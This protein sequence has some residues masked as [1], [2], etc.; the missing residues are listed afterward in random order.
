V[1][2]SGC[3]HET[4]VLLL[5]TLQRRYQPSHCWASNQSPMRRAQWAALCRLAALLHMTSVL[6][7]PSLLHSDLAVPDI[8]MMAC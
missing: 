2:G 1:H 5:H 4:D 6:H 3:T 7:W 8:M